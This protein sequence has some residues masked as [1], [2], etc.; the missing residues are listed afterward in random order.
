M[1]TNAKLRVFEAFV[2]HG[3]GSLSGVNTEHMEHLREIN[4]LL[5]E[6]I[7]KELVIVTLI[8]E[9]SLVTAGEIRAA[10]SASEQHTK[11]LWNGS[12]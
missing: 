8:T 9:R 11:P 4:E 12:L 10:L 7:S 6:D 3:V 5:L 1:K 2:N